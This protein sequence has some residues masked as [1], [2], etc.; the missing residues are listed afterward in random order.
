M[1]SPVVQ[2]W[3]DAVLA[4]LKSN[5]VR[6]IPYVPDR[7]LTLLIK[8]LHPDPFIRSKLR[9]KPPLDATTLVE[10]A[11]EINRC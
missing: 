3:H 11:G 5:S 7:V 8:A 1:S 6:L 10:Y 2:P 9:T 4:S